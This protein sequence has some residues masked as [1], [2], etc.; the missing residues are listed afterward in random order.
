PC[1]NLGLIVVDEEQEATYKNQQSPRYNTRDVA[2]KRAQLASIPIVLGSATPSLETWHNCARFAH[3]ER[4]TLPKRIAGLSMP[5]V[6]F[7]D[8]RVEAR[9]RPGSI[10]L[11]SLKMERELKA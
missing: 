9:N 6:E 8:M 10:H 4:I 11:L 2:L 3:F 1:P 7:V 5:A